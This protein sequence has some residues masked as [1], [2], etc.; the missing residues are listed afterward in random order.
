[1]KKISQIHSDLDASSNIVLAVEMSS[2]PFGLFMDHF[3][4]VSMA[5]V[6]RILQAVKT[7]TCTFD[8]CPS[9][10]LLKSCKGQ[11]NEP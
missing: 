5:D 1:M 2:A 8:P 11:I 9:T 4:V 3:N 10:W 7:A 6:Y